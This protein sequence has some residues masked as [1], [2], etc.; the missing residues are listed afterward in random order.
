[1]EHEGHTYVMAVRQ[2]GQIH[3][4]V[5]GNDGGYFCGRC[6]VVVLDHKTFSDLAALGIGIRSANDIQFVVL[7]MVDLAAVPQEKRHLPFD[8]KSNP[9]PLVKFTNLGRRGRR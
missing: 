7:G 9:L 5:V 1:L 8:D 3:P 2:R 6:P 4:L